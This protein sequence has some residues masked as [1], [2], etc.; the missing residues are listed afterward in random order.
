MS[1]LRDYTESQVK[2]M[3]VQLGPK[4]FITALSNACAYGKV[5]KDAGFEGAMYRDKDD[6]LLKEWYKGIDQLAK[7]T[8]RIETE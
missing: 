4:G 3:I 6:E 7:I 8:K 5:F 2:H 1:K